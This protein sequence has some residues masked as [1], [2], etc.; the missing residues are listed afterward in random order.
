MTDT[1][2]KEMLGCYG[3]KNMHTPNLDSL[4]AEGIRYENAYTCQPVCGPA[5]SSIFT[6]LF[7]HSNGMITNGLPLGANV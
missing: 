3:N 2:C 4:A 1:T 6:G 5:R 7:P